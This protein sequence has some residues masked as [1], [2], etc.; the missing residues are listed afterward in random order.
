[1]ENTNR[2]I[3]LL[4]DYGFKVTFADEADTLF[5]RKSL[6]A[7]I[8]SPHEIK[9]IEFLRNEFPGLTKES[10]GGV[11]DLSCQDENGNYFIVEMQLGHYK[12]FIQR[13]KFYAF[14]RLNTLV[15][16]GKYKFDSLTPIYCI[17]FLAK[18]IYPK[19]EQYYHFATLKNQVGEELD[20]QIVH[21]IVEIGKF[22]KEPPK[23]N[24]DLDK[25]IYIMKQSDTIKDSKQLPEFA[26]EDWIAQALKKVDKSKMTSEQRMWFEMSMAKKGSILEMQ[27]EERERQRAEGR[28]EG[29]AEG[30][31]EGEKRKATEA[32]RA[33]KKDEMP[34]DKIALY[35]GLSVEEIEQ[36]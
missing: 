9:E 21:I 32:A 34:T 2:F 7:L 31:V 5:L 4:S 18:D 8:Q 23:I 28:A 33:M 3:S 30:K 27:R 13:A 25:L 26:Q 35:T 19:S 11:Y 15:E 36:L 1:M 24:K 14:H 10:R 22:D 17:S 12:H 16:R 29:K 20:R 6:A